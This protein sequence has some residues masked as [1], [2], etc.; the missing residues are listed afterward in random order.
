MALCSCGLP[1]RTSARFCR[2]CRLPLPPADQISVAG[3]QSADLGAD[4]RADLG[5]HLIAAPVAVP[6]AVLAAVPGKFRQPPAFANGLLYAQRLDGSLLELST[7]RGAETRETGR[8]ELFGAGFNRGAVVNIPPGE[9][10]HLRGWTYLAASPEGIEA[11][12]LA[13][14][15]NI[16][17]HRAQPGRSIFANGSEDEILHM[18]GLAADS[19]FAAFIAHNSPETC[20]L[21]R[22]H[23]AADRPAETLF[24]L[25]GV[26]V[27]GPLIQGSLLAFCTE[28]QVGF[29]GRTLGART[30]DFPPFFHPYLTI[31][32]TGLNL[33][34]GGLPLVIASSAE[35]LPTLLVAGEAN[36]RSG[37]L[38]IQP[39]GPAAPR[40]R[41]LPRGSA[42][43]AG[44]NGSACLSSDGAIESWSAGGNR[45]ISAGVAQWMPATSTGPW[46]VWFGDDSFTGTHRVE[47]RGPASLSLSFESHSCTPATCFGAIVTGHDL[48]IGMLNPGAPRGTAELE[49][50][51][52]ALLDRRWKSKN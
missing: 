6:A 23:L 17:L 39:G 30:A 21:M 2:G 29:Y 37:L 41:P 10:P 51:T 16:V 42:L 22:L 40:F 44:W 8:L 48:V 13:T 19:R 36:G 46:L 5:A 49:F 15:K 35:Q 7:Q 43:H 27:A 25:H 4:L 45:R 18:R 52:W 11:L 31:A 34:P 47:A 32:D 3:A 28:R 50:A 26:N 20:T 1:N 38:E 12:V 33:P 9:H 14:G 24:S